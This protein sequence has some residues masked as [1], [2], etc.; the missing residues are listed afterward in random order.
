M[1]KADT[2]EDQRFYARQ[3]ESLGGVKVEI[4]KI[5]YPMN[6]GDGETGALVDMA[7]GGI[8]FA[9]PGRYEPGT[10]LELKI[11]LAGWQRYKK[12]Y[13][14]LIDDDVAVAP[15]TAVGEVIWCKGSPGAGGVQVGV[16][17]RDIY[18][19]DC[20]AMR[21]YLEIVR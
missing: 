13:S 20:Q 19:D 21:R 7:E 4:K 3:I 9:A 6:K 8:G 14:R 5:T 17:F 2:V 1:N 18:E 12:S 15:L 16:K 10:L 11:H